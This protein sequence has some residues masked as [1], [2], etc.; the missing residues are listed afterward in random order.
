MELVTVYNRTSKVVHGTWDGR[1][2]RIEPKKKVSLPRLVAEAIKRQNVLMGSEN[3]Y[4]GDM[5]FL[6]AIEE[7]NDPNFDL[8]QSPVVT[9]M[10][11][12]PLGKNEEVVKGHNGLYSLRDLEPS[13]SLHAGGSGFVKP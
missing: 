3:P 12:K 6:V 10:D 13:P 11:R 7:D 8:E 1:P 4:T 2:Y 9:R 5:Q